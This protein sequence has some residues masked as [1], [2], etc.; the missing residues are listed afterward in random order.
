[1]PDEIRFAT[2]PA[3]ASY[4]EQRAPEYDEWYLSQGLFATRHRPGWD[5][6]VEQLTRLVA[7]LSP[8]RTLD[9]ACGSG[10]L[11]R[12]LH[13]PTVATDRSRSMARIARQRLSGRAV[14]VADALALPFRSGSFD[15][16]MTGHFYGHLP[17]GE[18]SRFLREASRVASELVIIDSAPQPGV[19]RELVQQR[20]LNDGSRHQVFKRYLSAS[21][22]AAEI[23]GQVIYDG[24]C[25]VAARRGTCA[26]GRR[27]PDLVR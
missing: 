18:R 12:H 8:A 20:V 23:D 13:G 1:M 9:V 14:V 25:F 22:L 7:S 4:Y 17:P 16:V 21:E 27:R 10:F 26:K 5:Q 24:R 15:R 6:E 3:T 2:D 19:P 11:T